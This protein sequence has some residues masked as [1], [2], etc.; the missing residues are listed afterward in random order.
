LLILLPI[1]KNSSIEAADHCYD[2]VYQ[3]EKKN[4]EITYLEKTEKSGAD[5]QTKL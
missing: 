4:D 1:L 3:V 5:D 2:D